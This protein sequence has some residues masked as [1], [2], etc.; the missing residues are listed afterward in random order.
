MNKFRKLLNASLLISIFS[1]VVLLIFT[2]DSSTIDAIM[3]VKYEYIIAAAALHALSYLIWGM[4]TKIMCQALGHN[5]DTVKAVEI[6][7]SS[8]LAAAVTPSSAGGE[9]L[10]IHLLHRSK[11]PIGRATAVVI[12]ERLMDAI[13]LLSIVPFALFV[14][15]DMLSNY[16]LDAIFIVAEALVISLFALIIYGMWKPEQA[17]RLI[18]FIVHRIAHIFGKKTE[19]AL[20]PILARVDLELEHFHDSVWMFLTE[21]RKG[22]LYGAACTILFWIVEYTILPVILMGLDQSPPLIVVF[23]AQV[24]LSI[25]IVVPATPGAS[26]IAEFGAMTLFSVFVTSSLLGIT[27]VA[28]RALTFYMNI[29]VGSFVSIKILKDTDMIGKLLGD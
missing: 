14:F 3:G 20:S 25:I 5:I 2:V 16:Q 13:L 4:R 9:P 8:T 6:V 18:H 21:G 26:G 10:R 23:A 27:V 24:L 17:K 12:G 7:T 28:W 29:L 1:I 15:R 19:A 22:L 11:M